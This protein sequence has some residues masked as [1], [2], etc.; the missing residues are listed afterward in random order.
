MILELLCSR[1]VTVVALSLLVLYHVVQNVTRAY[2]L[3]RI[4]GPVHARLSSVV[5][6]WHTLRNTRIS[7]IH[8]LHRRYGNIVVLGPDEV[9]VNDAS[10][11]NQIYSSSK[12]GKHPYYTDFKF[13]GTQ[14]LF[15]TIDPVRHARSR[16]QF[17]PLYTRQ[18]LNL[19]VIHDSI[20]R[21][22]GL[23][24]NREEEVE[25]T[26]QFEKFTQSVITRFVFGQ[27]VELGNQG[28]NTWRKHVGRLLRRTDF[29]G[30]G[31]LADL[32]IPSTAEPSPFDKSVMES[33]HAALL[34]PVSGEAEK[35]CLISKM[36]HS[37][38]FTEA[39]ITSE[40]RD[41]LI[42]GS[43][44]TTSV[45]SF[46]F[47]Q[48]AISPALTDRLR[49]E[50]SRVN[51]SRYEEVEKVEYLAATIREALRLYASIPM[52][53][54][55]ITLQQITLG[56]YSVPAGTKIGSQ[57]YSLHRVDD[58]PET[59][60]PDNGGRGERGWEFSS[61]SRSCI[62]KALALCELTWLT[63]IL[64]S[65]FDFQTSTT[66]ELGT[67]EDILGFGTSPKNPLMMTFTRRL[68]SSNER[69]HPV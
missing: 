57:A 19:Q 11:L 67:V 21:L 36:V 28:V 49:R 10:L 29:M 51:L 45:L 69:S 22:V 26:E 68:I 31:R 5:V 62:G 39:E 47:H 52:T 7:Y 53:L 8:N 20:N 38:I 58:A 61:G 33:T 13:R 9:H 50:L 59:F 66:T 35:Q 56:G 54:P 55:R 37:G 17:S 3:R 64:V 30:L 24:D 27:Q 42:A 18:N 41:H 15:S 12:V 48:L 46:L 23:L 14:N 25:M 44:T 2:G 1:T 43:D 65:Q 40:V 4:P 60:D 32:V 34:Q 63:A 16:K 6:S